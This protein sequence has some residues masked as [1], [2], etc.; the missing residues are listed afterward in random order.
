MSASASLFGTQAVTG[1]SAGSLNLTSFSV[2]GNVIYGFGTTYLPLASCKFKADGQLQKAGGS[3]A[4]FLTYTNISNQWHTSAPA[5]D[6]S[7]YEI[8]FNTAANSPGIGVSATW[9]G[10]TENDWISL[11]FD[12]TWTLQKDTTFIGSNIW[13]VPI[14]V[15]EIANPS[16]TTG[17][18]NCTFSVVTDN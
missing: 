11:E 4:A 17:P 12:R 15:R 8:Y 6:G 1:A 7:L 9:F 10:P 18:V 3:T 16:N 5:V 13:V 2:F 14:E